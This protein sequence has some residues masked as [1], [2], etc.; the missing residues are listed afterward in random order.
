MSIFNE[1]WI[2][3]EVIRIQNLFLVVGISPVILVLCIDIMFLKTKQL[4]V[5]CE[6]EF[7]SVVEIEDIC[8][9]VSLRSG[10]I[11]LQ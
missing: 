8:L 7:A 10:E 5:G 11:F 2:H 1:F 9:V 6:R 3:Q 4:I